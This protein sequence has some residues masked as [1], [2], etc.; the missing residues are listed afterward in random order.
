MLLLLVSKLHII[1]D[2]APLH[3][4]LEID[5]DAIKHLSR[6][7]VRVHSFVTKNGNSCRAV[8]ELRE[9]KNKRHKHANA[10]Q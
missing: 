1:I 3:H 6:F 4:L 5:R 8:N 9:K 2:V 10:D 7:R